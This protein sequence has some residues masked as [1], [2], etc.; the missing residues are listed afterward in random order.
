MRL[1]SVLAVPT[2]VTYALVKGTPDSMMEYLTI[3]TVIVFMLTGLLMYNLNDIE[4]FKKFL[5][6]IRQS[7]GWLTV[8]R[9]LFSTYTVVVALYLAIYTDGMIMPLIYSV[10]I[11]SIGLSMVSLCLALYIKRLQKKLSAMNQAC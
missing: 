11:Y 6:N 9:G 3:F 5:F 4:K 10:I 2:V 8:L 1:F 7:I